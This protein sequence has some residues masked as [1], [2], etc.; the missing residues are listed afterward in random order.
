[1]KHQTGFSLIEALISIIILAIG[2]LGLAGLQSRA[3]MMNQSS[4]Y[5]GIATDLA[6]DLGDK[7]RA[8]RTPFML[9]SESEFQPGLP[10]DYSLC[11]PAL[12]DPEDIACGTQSAGRST[13]LLSEDMMN[14]YSHLR[15]Q[16]PN[17]QFYL[18]SEP[19]GNFFKYTLTIAWT[20]NRKE[21]SP[22]I[23]GDTDLEKIT[24][25]CASDPSSSCYVTV[26]E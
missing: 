14:W 9:S 12:N 24:N 1:M 3:M 10:P 17:A 16:L 2:L 23:N 13:Y 20:D 25:R 15:N 21:T 5:R 6:S 4:Y 26:I 19:S 22:V 18:N 7:I 8:S 11:R